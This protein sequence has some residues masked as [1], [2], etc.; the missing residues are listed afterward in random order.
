M[1]QSGK[2]IFRIQEANKGH[3]NKYLNNM[4]TIQKLKFSIKTEDRRN[5]ADTMK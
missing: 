1:K 5:Q 4:T 3:I 2:T